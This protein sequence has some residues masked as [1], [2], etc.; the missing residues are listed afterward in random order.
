M[1]IVMGYGGF[2][3]RRKFLFAH[4]VSSFIIDMS[5]IPNFHD[6][7][8]YSH[9]ELENPLSALSVRFFAGVVG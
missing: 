1:L 5:I 6:N 3:I 7:V 9:H 8:S 4:R 2:L